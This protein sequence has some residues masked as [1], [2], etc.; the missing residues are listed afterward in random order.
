MKRSWAAAYALGAACL[1]VRA[2]AGETGGPPELSLQEL[3]ELKVEVASKTD[4]NVSEA[5]GVVS[6]ITRREISAFGALNL[7]EVLDRAPSTQILSSHFL[8][9]AKAS[10]RGMMTSHVDHHVLMLIDGRPFRDAYGYLSNW[11]L[12]SSFPVDLI[13]R[14]EI[15]RGPGSVL[16]G[17]GAIAGVINIVTREPMEPFSVQA[18]GGGGSFGSRVVSG[19]AL[20]SWRD[21]KLT[22]GGS[23]LGQD[24]WTMAAKT[25][26]DS[27]VQDSS[28][29]YGQDDKSAA[30]FLEF[31]RLRAQVTYID[32]AYNYLGIVPAWAASGRMWSRRLI[33]D[34]GYTQPL[35]EAWS[36]RL[37]ATHNFWEHHV[38]EPPGPFFE[39][40][41]VVTTDAM[42]LE[43]V[44][45][46]RL[47]ERGGVLVGG[48]T[49]NR[50]NRD[51]AVPSYDEW[52]Y[53]GYASADYRFIDPLKLIAGFQYN[54]AAQDK[55]AWV[56]RL[57]AIYSFTGDIALKLLYG[58]AF[59]VTTPLEEYLIIPG[60]LI[61]NKDLDPEF[62]T[63]CDA[64]LFVNSSRAQYTFT[65]YYGRLN[66]LIARV[67]THPE[68]P[69]NLE[70]TY[71]NQERYDL[72]GAE[73]EIKVP[74]TERLYGTGSLTLQKEKED[75]LFIP[76]FMAKGG[77]FYEAR[78]F[79][80]GLFGSLF[81]R[82]LQARGFNPATEDLNPPAEPIFLL[83]LNLKYDFRGITG[84]PVTHE[85]RGTNLLDDPMHYP[86]FSRNEVNTLPMGPG[87]AILGRVT[88]AY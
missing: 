81:G 4:E 13:E 71:V 11:T 9:Q 64:Q 78:G 52:L 39:G 60:V 30:A 76:D 79:T 47:G 55:Q 15:V 42:L 29:K 46:G 68:E 43:G 28:M 74:L 69:G 33:S 57:G 72:F 34:V 32:A 51:T 73:L 23:Y 10:I 25:K 59:R 77:L 41:G 53:S 22:V 21:L 49:E 26:L 24:G 67:F 35:T 85:A 6:V 61:G 37:N 54:R 87:R 18:S 36:I 88:V 2:L 50:S 12:Y 70:E 62:V 63:T 3:L 75:R 5:P 8:R 66:D 40:G 80:G 1:A 14:I 27:W 31:K 17:S 82:G 16:Y 7:A 84:V 48:L 83:S 19:L 86:E 44:L 38:Y 65:L 58:R 20:L 45:Q 56:P